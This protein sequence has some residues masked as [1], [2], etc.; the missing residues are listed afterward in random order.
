MIHLLTTI[1]QQLIITG[2]DK[3]VDINS[4]LLSKY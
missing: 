4:P 1:I 2:K 3:T